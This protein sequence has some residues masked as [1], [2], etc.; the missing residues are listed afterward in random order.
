MYL[1]RFIED[2]KNLFVK[3]KVNIIYGPRRTGKTT[4]INKILDSKDGNIFRGTGDD[5]LIRNI[6]NSEDKNKIISNFEDYDIIFIDEAQRISKIG[7][8]L[9]I[10]IDEFPDKTIIITGSSSFQLSYK[11]GTPLTGRSFVSLLFPFSV[12]ELKDEFGGMKINSKLEE[13]LIYGMYPESIT[14]KSLNSKEKYLN[15]LLNSY[16][17]KDILELE[18]IKNSDKLYDLLRLLAFQIGDEVSTNELGNSLS[19]SKHTVSRYLDL[20]EKSFIIKKIGGFSR[21]L[22]KEVTKS[23]RYYFYD[24]GIRNAIIKNYNPI[25]LREDIGMLWENF[26]VMERLKHQEYNE[27]SSNNYFWRTY[28][29]KEIDWIEERNGNLFAYEI[30]WKK[31]KSKH[32]KAWLNAYPDAEFNIINRDNFFEFLV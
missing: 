24:N 31:S 3:G 12:K 28:D 23:N 29:Q 22:R 30:K 25:E 20:L 8:G 14:S 32:Q 2:K 7:W 13:Y 26:V 10:I 16:L 4:L 11:T 9:K 21:N 27:I 6:L 15:N 17:F 1:K 19:I 5:I 18:N